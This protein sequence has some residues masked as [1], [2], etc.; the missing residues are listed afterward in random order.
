MR[1][2]HGS[3]GGRRFRLRVNSKGNGHGVSEIILRD[4]LRVTAIHYGDG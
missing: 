2:K 4:M 1:T 3:E